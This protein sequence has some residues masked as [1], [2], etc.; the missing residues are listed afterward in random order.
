MP[1]QLSPIPGASKSQQTAS[2]TGVKGN[3]G[4]TVGKDLGSADASSVADL[5]CSVS[6]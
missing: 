5:S 3:A 4:G 1:A 2:G 6:E